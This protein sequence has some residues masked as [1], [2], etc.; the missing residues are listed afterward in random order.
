MGR[1]ARSNPRS[2][3]GG[4]PKAYCSFQRCVRAV[5]SFGND[6]VGFE[7]WLASTSATEKHC[8]AMRKIWSELHPAPLVALQSSLP[9]AALLAQ[10]QPAPRPTHGVLIHE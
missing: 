10:L 9:D 7:R 3:E 5:R 6:L 4:K 2:Q 8:T 1:A